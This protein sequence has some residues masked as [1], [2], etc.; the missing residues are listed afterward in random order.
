MTLKYAKSVL[1]V[2]GVSRVSS[3][4]NKW[5]RLIW[6]TLYV[7]IQS[8]LKSEKRSL[9]LPLTL[10]NLKRFSK[11]F[12]CLREEEIYNNSHKYIL[13]HL[14]CVAA[15]PCEVT[16]A[17]KYAVN[18]EENENKMHWICM[19]WTQLFS[20]VLYFWLNITWFSGFC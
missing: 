12:H 19:Y 6:P 9:F 4:W 13:P 3:Y 18:M 5:P 10:W 11:F 2:I 17:F 8:G 15:L 20:L 1:D 7:Y 14:K 16:D